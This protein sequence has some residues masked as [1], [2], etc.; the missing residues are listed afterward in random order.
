MSNTSERNGGRKVRGQRPNWGLRFGLIGLFL[1][2]LIALGWW[3]L[4]RWSATKNFKQFD[5]L[6]FNVDC[7]GVD[8]SYFEGQILGI[9][10]VNAIV[11]YPNSEG[12]MV[13]EELRPGS[14]VYADGACGRFAVAVVEE[15]VFPKE[16]SANPPTVKIRSYY[17][18][19]KSDGHNPI[20]VAP[21]PAEHYQGMAQYTLNPGDSMTIMVR[22]E[23]VNHDYVVRWDGRS[24][25]ADDGTCGLEDHGLL[26]FSCGGFKLVRIIKILDGRLVGFT[27]HYESVIFRN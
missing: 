22:G 15:I 20:Q 4:A 26:T 6:I 17:F 19:A 1:L 10:E 14:V 13:A 12:R 7:K 16:P 27:Q 25:R 21:P 23:R 18:P 11:T 5:T 3:G 9:S 24:L 2:A 8:T